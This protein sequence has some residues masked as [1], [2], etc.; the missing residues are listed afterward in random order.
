MAKMSPALVKAQKKYNRTKT[1]SFTL[2]LN[3]ETDA[4]VIERLEK[5]ENKQGY[6]KE[7]IRKDIEK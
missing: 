3:K 6:I 1:K 7:L 2:K 5:A 4:D